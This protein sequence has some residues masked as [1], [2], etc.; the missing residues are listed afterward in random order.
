MLAW[1][2]LE[3]FNRQC[4]SSVPLS[5]ILSPINLTKTSQSWPSWSLW[6]LMILVKM[7]FVVEIMVIIVCM[8]SWF[9]KPLEQVSMKRIILGMPR[10]VGESMTLHIGESGSRRLPYRWVGSRYLIYNKLQNFI[11]QKLIKRFK[12]NFQRV[13]LYTC[14]ASLLNFSS[15]ALS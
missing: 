13:F 7:I 6:S 3:I 9:S 8:L 4:L 5:F 15:L 12:P 1:V 10:W 11:S 14:T 2:V